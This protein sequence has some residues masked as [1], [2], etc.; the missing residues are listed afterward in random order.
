MPQWLDVVGYEEGE[1]RVHSQLKCGYPRFV[2]HPEVLKLNE[3]CRR[4]LA[5]PRERAL[6]FPTEKVAF[7]CRSFLLKN[8]LSAVHVVPLGVD[9]CA[10]LITGEE[11][12]G[13]CKLYWQHTGE[14]LSSRYASYIIKALEARA[15]SA[16]KYFPQSASLSLPTPAAPRTTEVGKRLRE[17]IGS[18]YN[19]SSE[20][21]FLF[22]TGM[23]AIYTAYRLLTNIY[24]YRKAV[25]FGFPYLDTLKM[26]QRTEWG[27]G[28]HFLHQGDDADFV[29]LERLL[30]DEK[31]LGV[32]LEFPCNPLLTCIDL[33]RLSRLA[34][35]FNFPIVVDDTILGPC[36]VDLFKQNEVDIVVSSLTKIFSGK[37]NTMG[38][39]LVFNGNSELYSKLNWRRLM[40]EDYEDFLFKEDAEVL[41]NNSLDL[42]ARV[43]QIDQTTMTLVARLRA[44]P[45]VKEVYYTD[46]DA[47]WTSIRP[48][49]REFSEE[50]TAGTLGHGGLFSVVFHG[51]QKASERFYDALKVAKGPS[52]GTNFTLCCPYTLLAHYHEL[53]FARSCGVDPTLIRIWVGLEPIE[54]VWA[55]LKVALA[56]IPSALVT[57][58][59]N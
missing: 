58:G 3:L 19:Q 29:R 18:L 54:E 48:Y 46:S 30:A 39:S 24:P 7:R 34:K 11:N 10:A 5:G 38:G 21:V 14:L 25:I 37:G 13:I 16:G 15:Q 35:R 27:Q 9:A 49:A 28:V 59:L 32:F 36:H 53:D 6:V 20:N 43:Y 12:M 51:G 26:M 17:R 22:P 8:C 31:I 4:E 56:A 33:S 44:E 1:E 55:A 57:N 23:S 52:L 42:H 47:N 2:Y 45:A 50:G 41:L 40:E